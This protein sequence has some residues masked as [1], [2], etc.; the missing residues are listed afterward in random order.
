MYGPFSAE[1]GSTAYGC[2]SCPW[3]AKQGKFIFPCPRSRLRIWCRET[4][5]AV[6]SGVSLFI[7]HTQAESSAYSR[8]VLLLLAFRDIDYDDKGVHLYC[9]PPPGQ[10]RAYQVPQLRT[11]GV[12]RRESIGTGPV[13]LKVARVTSALP[14]QVC[15][16]TNSCASNFSHAHYWY[17]VDMCDT[18]SIA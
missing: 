10:S 8:A 18:H 11:D 9:Q 12:H 15:P 7:L 4:G 14:V 5:S 17:A 16:W 2:Q 6:P 13:V 3:S 1:Y